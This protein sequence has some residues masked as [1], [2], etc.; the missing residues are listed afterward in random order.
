M[1]NRVVY[2]VLGVSFM[3]LVGRSNG[4]GNCGEEGVWKL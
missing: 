3:S 2:I 4:L 1:L